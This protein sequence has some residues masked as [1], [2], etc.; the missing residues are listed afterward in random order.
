MRHMH[1][2]V[3]RAL[4]SA[5]CPVVAFLLY[6]I[7][8]HLASAKHWNRL[9]LPMFPNFHGLV[10]LRALQSSQSSRR[11]LRLSESMR[12]CTPVSTPVSTRICTRIS[13]PYLRASRSA[14][15][16]DTVLVSELVTPQLIAHG[17][18]SAYSTNSAACSTYGQ[19]LCVASPGAA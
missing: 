7:A 6:C 3:A 1:H 2:S 18:G 10:L 13:H 17:I 5:A 19:S 15:I 8:W 9:I 4:S 16:P 14:S 12:T 11:F